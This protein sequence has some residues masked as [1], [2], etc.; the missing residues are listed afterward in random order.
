MI[1]G[2]QILF[3]KFEGLRHCRRP[4]ELMLLQA[5]CV[6]VQGALWFVMRNVLRWLCFAVY[7]YACLELQMPN[8]TVHACAVFCVASDPWCRSADVKMCR[9]CILVHC[10][11]SGMWCQIVSNLVWGGVSC[12]VATISHTCVHLNSLNV[13]LLLRMHWCVVVVF[14][15]HE[16]CMRVKHVCW[17]M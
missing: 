6:C 3:D 17:C 12:A 14:L 2:S 5:V 8:C 1:L 16:M 7:L 11:A 15:G 4:V 13:R 9:A 10:V